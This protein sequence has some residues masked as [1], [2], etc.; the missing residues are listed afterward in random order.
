MGL[1]KPDL[2]RSFAIGFAIGAAALG[3][4]LAI[5]SNQSLAGHVIPTAEAAPAK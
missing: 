1:F 3:A 2:F 4:T 5:P